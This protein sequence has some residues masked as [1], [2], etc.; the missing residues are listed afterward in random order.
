MR[1]IRTLLIVVVG[2]EMHS[3]VGNKA[4]LLSR[5]AM[6]LEV[7]AWVLRI[8]FS[9]KCKTVATYCKC[10]FF[11]ENNDFNFQIRQD[12]WRNCPQTP[13]TFYYF[14]FTVSFCHIINV[15]IRTSQNT[16]STANLLFKASFLQNWFL[17]SFAGCQNKIM[18]CDIFRFYLKNWPIIQ[19]EQII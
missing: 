13:N 8:S 2:Y 9:V 7:V 5:V 19:I 14:I 4:H 11:T 12:C 15:S 1:C 10:F 3:F 17:R 18:N 6:R 16:W